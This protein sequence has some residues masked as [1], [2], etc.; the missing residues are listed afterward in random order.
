VVLE[1]QPEPQPK[2][3]ECLPP[4]ANPLLAELGLAEAV[5][6]AGRASHGNRFV[7]GSADPAERDFIFGTAGV[8]WQLDRR[9]FEQELTD[10]AIGAGVDWRFGHRLLSCTPEQRG[11]HRLRVQTRQGV[12]T[13][14]A[15]F[16]IDASGRA[17]RL[18]HL[19]GQRRVRYDRLVAVVTYFQGEPRVERPA[20]DSSTLVEADRQGWWYSAHLPGG[21]LVAAYLTDADLLGHAGPDR[22]ARWSARLEGAPH[23]QQ[24]LC[25]GSYMPSHPGRVVGAQTSRLSAVAGQGWLAAGD[26][27]VAHDPLTSYGI[28]AALA[29]GL[30]AGAAAADYLDGRHQALLDYARLMD[31][32]FARYL[33]LHHDRYL[34]EQRWPDSPFWRRRQVRADG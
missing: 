2:V 8:G 27:A 10:A 4:S 16:V 25:Q 30:H 15:D 14:Q 6:R 19:L 11:V 26:A 28:T 5:G 22:E 31:R 18:A 23:T 34:A 1:A 13:Y 3:G 29:W 9:R 24:R 20:D 33:V 32:A 21:R 17:A 12:E 7:W